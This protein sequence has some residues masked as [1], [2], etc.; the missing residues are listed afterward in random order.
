MTGRYALGFDFGTESIRVVVVGIEDGRMAGEAVRPFT[1]GVMDRE[2]PRTGKPLPPDFALQDPEDY[3]TGIEEA[4]PE[5]LAMAKVAPD[6]IAGI[7]IDFTACTPLPV[8][9][10]G[11]PLCSLPEFAGEPHAMVKLWKHHGANEEAARINQVA[12][13]R[14]ESFLKRYGG[15]TSSEWLFAK[16]LE[17]R[18][19]APGV[20]EAMDR[21]MEASDWVVLQL[22]G[23]ESRGAC[24][25]GYKGMWHGKYGYPG[26]DFFEAVEPGLS[27]C[28]RLVGAHFIPAGRRAGAVSR[29]AAARFGLKAGTPV[30]A[31]II[32]AHA[33][34]PACGVADSGRMVIILGT[35]SCHMIMDEKEFLV[36]GIQ[37][38]VH[39][40]ILPGF[41]GYEAGQ[42]ATGDIF[43]WFV[44]NIAA[45]PEADDAAQAGAFQALQEK[46]ARIEPGGCGLVALDWWNGNRS[47]LINPE[48]TGLMVGMTMNTR[49]EEIF[50]ALMEATGFG[51]RVIIE[52]FV[53]QGVAVDEVIV[54]GGIAEKNPALLKIYADITRRPLAKAAAPQTCALGAAICGAAAAGKEAGGYDTVQEAVA[55]MAPTPA[56]VYQPDPEASAVYDRVFGLYRQLH[57]FFGQ[58]HP[59]LMQE[60][61]RNKP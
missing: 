59:A 27:A 61:K 19:K 10:D 38:V 9:A 28:K 32:D 26:D 18:R 31:A 3:L 56:E 34:V 13:D 8:K 51:T 50:R 52:N 36:E 53:G 20:Y 24:A 60:L 12:L 54:C 23:Q 22:T 2:F 47:I 35:S 4:L 41:Y 15:T 29:E 57:D 25:A 55:R 33:A 43:A 17:T 39:E 37:G 44:K 48:L 46:A 45:G 6:R 1:H 16:L 21:F 11:T 30:S 14:G 58:E 42:A 40:G 5:A 49:P 7:G